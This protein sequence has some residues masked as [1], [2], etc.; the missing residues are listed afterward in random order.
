MEKIDD[1]GSLP[2]MAVLQSRSLRGLVDKVNDECIQKDDIV[3][4]LCDEEGF[5]LIYYK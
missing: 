2:I 5:S 3:Q 4:L 1:Y